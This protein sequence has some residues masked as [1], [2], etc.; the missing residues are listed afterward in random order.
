MCAVPFSTLLF[1]SVCVAFLPVNEASDMVRKTKKTILNPHLAPPVDDEQHEE[2][3]VSPDSSKAEDSSAS[4]A[5]DGSVQVPMQPKPP[6]TVLSSAK[7]LR[8]MEKK[9]SGFESLLSNLVHAVSRLSTV[10]PTD[11]GPSSRKT[12][13]G[14]AFS[15]SGSADGASDDRRAIARDRKSRTVPEKSKKAQKPSKEANKSGKSKPRDVKD[16]QAVSKDLEALKK[17]IQELEQRAL[18]DESS[19]SDEA[20]AATKVK[21]AA[22]YQPNIVVQAVLRGAQRAH[23]LQ[24]AT[25]PSDVRAKQAASLR[26]RNRYAPANLF[27]MVED[28]SKDVASAMTKVDPTAV[29]VYKT[30]AKAAGDLISVL[31]SQLKLL[32]FHPQQFGFMLLPPSPQQDSVVG[33][34][35]DEDEEEKVV[36]KDGQESGPNIDQLLNLLAAWRDDPPKEVPGNLNAFAASMV[37]S[38]NVTLS[39]LLKII[40]S[41]RKLVF[42]CILP[43]REA[44]QFL[45][46][47]SAKDIMKSTFILPTVEGKPSKR[48]PIF[49]DH[50]IDEALSLAQDIRAQEKVIPAAVESPSE[51]WKATR[52]ILTQDPWK[53]EKVNKKDVISHLPEKASTT[54]YQAKPKRDRYAYGN[55]SGNK[56]KTRNRSGSRQKH[57]RYRKRDHSYSSTSGSSA[58]TGSR[59]D[60]HGNKKQYKN[61]SSGKDYKK[62]AEEKRSN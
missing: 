41:M 3:P 40:M 31:R 61:N 39:A 38:V 22:V 55:S 23:V 57:D 21:P 16:S 11:S 15:S 35:E 32:Q 34:D 12:S 2:P 58:S 17:R 44:D 46:N 59:R 9:L 26:K 6:E 50:E 30:S 8:G 24:L 60:N 20:T 27:A 42:D 28:L 54:A 56:H 1:S 14:E 13:D 19:D 48:M 37:D 36:L 47:L 18:A 52:A 25:E 10:E 51:M 62:S 33:A 45:W 43:K 29:S 49:L 53:V 7:R 5:A 4:V